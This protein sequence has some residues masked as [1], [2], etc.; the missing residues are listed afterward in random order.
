METI[1]MKLIDLDA[2][3]PHLTIKHEDGVDVIPFKMIERLADGGL[4]A[5]ELEMSDK[6]IQLLMTIL[7]TEL[8][9]HF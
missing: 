6:T 8:E 4:K 5:S 1:G 3:R 2:Y 9:E 7:L